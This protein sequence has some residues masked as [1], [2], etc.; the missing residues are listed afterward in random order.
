M[1]LGYDKL[2]DNLDHVHTTLN[3]PR[4]LGKFWVVFSDIICQILAK[5]DHQM[6]NF[7]AVLLQC[8]KTLHH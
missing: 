8:E 1:F 6:A 7:A 5:C 2:Q 3:Y 4:I